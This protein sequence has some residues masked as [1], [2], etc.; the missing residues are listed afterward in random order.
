MATSAVG[1]YGMGDNLYYSVPVVCAR[2]H[3]LRIGNLPID[4]A[5]ASAMEASRL[6]LI[7]ERCVCEREA[8]YLII[9][10]GPPGG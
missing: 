10:W 8:G 9:W 1:M 5:S 7:K 4:E 2:G 3:V 6:A